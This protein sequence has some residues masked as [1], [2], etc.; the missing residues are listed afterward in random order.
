MS[1]PAATSPSVV[2]VQAN[3][4]QQEASWRANHS[5]WAA[6]LT[7][8]QHIERETWLLSIPLNRN[9]GL[10]PWILSDTSC[11]DSDRPP[12]SSLET[13][14]KPAIY[15][16]PK[17]G[18]VKDVTAY[19]I[20]SVFT[21][22][23]YRGRGYASKLMDQIGS[24]L[25]SRQAASP[26]AAQFSILFSDIGPKFYA[27]SGWIPRGNTHLEVKT[28]TTAEFA[29]SPDV[30]DIT[31]DMLPELAA[32][33]EQI[34]RALVAQPSSKCRVAVLPS[35]DSLNWHFYREDYIMNTIHGRKP[36]VRG[37]VWTS[38]TDS[39]VRVWGLFKRT[40]Y[41]G[42]GD[43]GVQVLIDVIHF[44]RLVI[45]DEKGSLSDD[46]L[47]QALKGIFAVANREAKDWG[48]KSYDTWNPSE[49]IRNV[50][51]EKLPELGAEFVQR[52][53]FEIASIKWF[54]NESDDDV[55]WVAN[56]K[57]CWC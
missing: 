46:E 47:A 20:A 28:D 50:V 38:P 6:S 35:V 25:A 51:T 16:D 26:G 34:V 53:K 37:A 23:E 17:D 12:L 24:E 11:S 10:V 15:R 43:D 27:K 7:V 32:R 22:K 41:D 52:D 57:Y 49:R 2:L 4:Q 1:L 45:D 54:G 39:A 13:I 9:G 18:V 19:G 5:S 21:L 55:E 3:P 56:E 8:E 31:D 40:R 36:T 42:V 29:A 33:D 48:C 30:K 44:M 14:R